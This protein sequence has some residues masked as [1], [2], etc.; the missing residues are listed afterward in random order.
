MSQHPLITYQHGR[1]WSFT[2]DGSHAP[3]YIL[4]TV[5]GCPCLER[6]SRL[7]QVLRAQEP[8]IHFDNGR[9]WASLSRLTV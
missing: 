8:H 3:A 6:M 9:F 5:R 7:R 2:F 4:F 1:T